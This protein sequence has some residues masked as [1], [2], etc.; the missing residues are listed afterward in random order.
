MPSPVDV[1]RYFAGWNTARSARFK[2]IYIRSAPQ[3]KAA[4]LV[5]TAPIAFAFRFLMRRL[6]TI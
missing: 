6:F 3:G 2:S 5:Q 4:M 1:V